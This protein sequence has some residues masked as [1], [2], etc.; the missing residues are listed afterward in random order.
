MLLR[1][2]GL[3]GFVVSWAQKHSSGLNWKRGTTGGGGSCVRSR[4]GNMLIHRL[5]QTLPS[6]IFP[7]LVVE[8]LPKNLRSGPCVQALTLLWF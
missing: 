2:V 7:V 3:D 5:Q 8:S 4:N 1:H 6:V